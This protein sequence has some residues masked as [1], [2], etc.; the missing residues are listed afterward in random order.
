MSTISQEIQTLLEA[1]D[2]NASYV[3]LREHL[4]TTFPSFDELGSLDE[5]A[6]SGKAEHLELKE[7]LD[8]SSSLLSKQIASASTSALTS[9]GAANELSLTRH[10]L[11]DQLS[12]LSERLLP[13]TSGKGKQPRTLLEDMEELHAQLRNLQLT[14][15]YLAVLE[16]ASALSEEAVFQIQSSPSGPISTSSL[17][18]YQELQNFVSSVAEKTQRI[19]SPSPPPLKLVEY[20]EIIRDRT[21]K[22]INNAVS[23]NLLAA[24]ERLQWPSPI[25]PSEYGSKDP[26]NRAAFEA[27][28][29]NLLHLQTAGENLHN[30]H[31][32]GSET[33]PDELKSLL[34]KQGLYPLQT[35]LQP[36]ALRFRYHFDGKRQTNRPDKPEWY[37]THV[38][39]LI[40][41]HRPFMEGVVQPLLQNSGYSDISAMD[42]F[43]RLMCN[44]PSRKL[45]KSIQ[46]IL[47]LPALLAHTIYQTLI[48]DGSVRD[49]GFQLSRT[50]EGKERLRLARQE[51]DKAREQRQIARHTAP[52]K[53]GPEK[54]HQEPVIEWE[55]L[56]DVIVGRREWF[57]SWLEGEK[58]FT[59]K[60]FNEIISASDA[61]VI[62]DDA[63]DNEDLESRRMVDLGT[64]ATT[65]ARR[66]KIL[67]ERVTE[68]YSPLPQ[69]A[70]KFRF[71]FDIQLS[72]LEAYLSRI[73]GSLDAY[74]RLS[75]SF[76]R[77]VPG[78]LASQVGH[79]VDT[80][81]MTSGVEGLS[82]L[83][84]ALVSGRWIKAAMEGWGEDLFFL[85]MWQGIQENPVLRARV[86][87]NPWFPPCHSIE[88][89]TDH[90]LF[91]AFVTRYDSLSDRAEE[92]IAN[93]V[94]SEIEGELKGYFASK[95][96]KIGGQDLSQETN[97]L[98]M[99]ATLVAP[100]SLLSSCLTFLSQSVPE[101][102]TTALYRRIAAIVT[103]NIIQRVIVGR[104]R[105][106]FS[107]ADG[108]AFKDECGMWVEA[109]RMALFGGSARDD[110]R[111]AKRVEHPWQELT[112]VAT[113]VGWPEK[114]LVDIVNA[115]L[116]GEDAD[117]EKAMI[118]IG[119][120]G[121]SRDNAR[122]LLRSRSDC[123]C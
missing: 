28:F 36:I 18:K 61:W 89:E 10:S 67:I 39:N 16:R 12:S 27:A 112:N 70:Q 44:L 92:M 40:H 2:T 86:E 49:S 111:L 3:R 81:H 32:M 26:A 80:R 105:H 56:T 65:S 83:V 96:E 15:D 1:P 24:A 38:L 53:R 87:S 8:A 98:S 82:R 64:R 99:P 35:L 68:R 93:Q 4:D 21:W 33:S 54:K 51:R 123:R 60:Q 11:A 9:L 108:Y 14:R 58:R 17:T 94:C 43:T 76:V 42:E 69:L 95:W 31:T 84:K 75:S 109:S 104:G 55:G 48:F 119:V 20:L 62:S 50:W 45:K 57:E 22:D 100:I 34:R 88:H 116:D 37:F 117:F 101:A 97:A 78:A 52:D 113:I 102:T 5:A 30:V 47:S 115:T 118:E 13:L 19:S 90:A 29:I 121:L 59:D 106:Q 110:P 7:Q 122:G 103:Q 85:E 6:R 23:Q 79:G 74:E 72:L 91:D 41:E 25:S 63:G 73:T 46:S 120:R 66:F 114:T 107:P 77:S 71:L